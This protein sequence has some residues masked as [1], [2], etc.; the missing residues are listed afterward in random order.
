ME[1]KIDYLNESVKD[2]CVSKVTFNDSG[3]IT[4]AG[5][6]E[7]AKYRNAEFICIEDNDLK[8]FPRGIGSVFPYLKHLTV[9]CDIVEKISREDFADLDHLHNLYLFKNQTVNLPGDVFN[10]LQMLKDLSLI[11]DKLKFVD[12]NL[13]DALVNLETVKLL[14]KSWIK[15]SEPERREQMIREIH[16]K[17][18]PP[19]PARSIIG[20]STQTNKVLEARVVLLENTITELVKEI[21]L[22]G[23]LVKAEKL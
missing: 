4:V 9:H 7:A 21:K 23:Q 14:G 6:I 22:S 8:K 17:Y 2:Y 20:L 15:L 12:V 1:L 18:K 3:K 19:A 5:N 13:F 11:S 16:E 10:D